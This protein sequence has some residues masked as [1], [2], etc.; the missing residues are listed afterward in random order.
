[1]NY[2]LNLHIK[3]SSLPAWGGGRRE[4]RIRKN[5]VETPLSEIQ[6]VLF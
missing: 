3:V 4:R 2:F 5:G 1:M 6:N